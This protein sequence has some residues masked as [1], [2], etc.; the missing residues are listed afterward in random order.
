LSVLTDQQYFQGSLDDLRAV[1]QA[2]DLPILRKDFLLD[3]YQVYEARAAGADA[4]LLIAA[5]LP[6]GTLMD[7][8]ILAAELRMTSLVEVHGADELIAVRSLIGFPHH[9]YSLLGINNRD[10]TNFHVDIFTTIRLAELAGEDVNIVS[11]SGIKTRSDIE[12]LNAAG[13]RAIL[14]G[15]TLM[16]SND[17]SA[18]VEQLLGPAVASR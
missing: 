1:R 2:V 6:P 17:I 5:A 7:L 4:I 13:V 3:A 16:R 10:L 14:V 12:R 11:E 9:S 15:E 18:K 8:M